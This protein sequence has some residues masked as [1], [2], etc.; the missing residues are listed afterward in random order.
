VSAVDE[1]IVMPLRH[2]AI[3][4]AVGVCPSKGVL[5]TGLPGSGKTTLMTALRGALSVYFQSINCSTAL[6]EFE[7]SPDDDDLITLGAYRKQAHD[8]TS[9]PF[10]FFCSLTCWTQAD[11][12]LS[13]HHLPF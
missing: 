8:F 4:K 3:F 12:Q 13:S 9:N 10:S 6:H 11:N 2:P 5:L 7:S 1:V